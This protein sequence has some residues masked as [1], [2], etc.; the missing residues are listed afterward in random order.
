VE[1]RHS[2]FLGFLLDPQKNHGL[3][4]AFA[5][6]LYER[7]LQ[8]HQD[9][10]GLVSPIDLDVWDMTGADVRREW[11]NIDILF[12]DQENKFVALIENKVGSGEHSGQLK[13]YLDTIERHYREWRVLAIFLTPDGDDPSEGA[14]LPL[15]NSTV[16][17]V[18]ASQAWWGPLQVA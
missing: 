15:D 8:R 3:G 4:D 10:Q 17:S 6:R 12:E 9:R 13:R 14:F 5:R 7:V 1:A 16:C 2:G 11:Q 18:V